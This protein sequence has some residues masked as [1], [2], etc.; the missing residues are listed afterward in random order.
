MTPLFNHPSYV[1][2]NYI[3]NGRDVGKY[4]SSFALKYLKR[5]DVLCAAL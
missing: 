2:E 5:Y 1:D 3:I 4:E